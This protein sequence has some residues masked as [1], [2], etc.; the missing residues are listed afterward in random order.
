[1]QE[2]DLCYTKD[3]Q[4]IVHHDSDLIRTTGE[5]LNID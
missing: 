3:K 1:M 5:F 4:L 2:L